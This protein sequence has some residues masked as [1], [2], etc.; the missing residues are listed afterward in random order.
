MTERTVILLRH[1]KS[2]RSGDEDDVA[3]PLS[4][5][6]R[7]QAPEAGR[8][9]N[10]SYPHIDLAVVS[11]AAR[12]QESW[13]LAAPEL[14]SPPPVRVD[15][16]IYAN[17]AT[18]LLAVLRDTPETASTVVLVGHNPGFEELVSHLTGA[19]IEM[20]T[21]AMAVIDVPGAWAAADDGS[22]TLRSHGR[23]P[24]S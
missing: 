21:S 16:R 3:R 20:P 7:R 17:V 6:G 12:A 9:L 15:D 1:A 8:W 19:S 2:D 23:P 14:D 22:A 10:A 24:I 13:E 18:D 11:P 4:D 5:R